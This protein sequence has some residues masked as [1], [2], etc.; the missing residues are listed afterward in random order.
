MD[1]VTASIICGCLTACAVSLFFIMLR[2]GAIH[3][4]LLRQREH[5]DVHEP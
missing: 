3:R 2:L 4:L 1:T 5:E